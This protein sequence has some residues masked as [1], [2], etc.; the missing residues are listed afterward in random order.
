MHRNPGL[1]P[2][3]FSSLPSEPTARPQLK[4]EDE[5]PVCHDA[6]PPKGPDGSETAREAH[7]TTC[8]ESHFSS[9]GL[10]SKPAPNDAASTSMSGHSAGSNPRLPPQGPPAT[11]VGQRRRTTGMV[12]Y[13]ATEKDCVGEDGQGQQ[14]CVICFEEFE[15]GDEMGRLEC[16]CKF[17][18][19]SLTSCKIQGFIL[20]IWE[21]VHKAMVG[22]QRARRL[23]SAS[24]GFMMRIS[25]NSC[26]L[27]C[28]YTLLWMI[29]V[30]RHNVEF[31]APFLL[32]AGRLELA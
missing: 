5:C 13:P 25:A 2:E 17:H 21:G 29:S 6:L 22:H 1:Y 8:I 19:V 11:V 24:R 32:Q 26:F 28:K 30:A 31:R 14:E 15:V 20:I 16:L 3:R 7:I 23:S 4:E 9:S 10:K 12:V 27:V 18:K